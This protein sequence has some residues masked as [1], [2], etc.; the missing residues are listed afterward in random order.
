MIKQVANVDTQGLKEQ[1]P[2]LDA[3]TISLIWS[4]VI[5]F[6]DMIVKNNESLAKTIP[7]VDS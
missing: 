4:V 1:F 5:A 7:H 2:T 6:S 3:N